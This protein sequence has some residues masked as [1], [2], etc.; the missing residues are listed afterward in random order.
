MTVQICCGNIRSDDP[1]HGPSRDHS[2]APPTSKNCYKD[3]EFTECGKCC[4]DYEEGGGGPGGG[5]S[6]CTPTDW[7]G[8]CNQSGS[9]DD[10]Y[11]LNNRKQPITE[12]HWENI[13]TRNFHDRLERSV[14]RNM[15]TIERRLRENIR[16]EDN[17]IRRRGGFSRYP[18]S[19]SE[20]INIDSV[21][22]KESAS[23]I[24]NE[25]ALDIFK[26]FIYFMGSVL[27]VGLGFL[28]FN[29]FRKRKQK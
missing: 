20:R 27:F 8:Y 13:N 19:S 24:A 22:N 15:D 9:E 6:S 14:S 4:D 7:G 11:Y 3:F 26:Y 28:V 23:E 16:H 1:V 2:R 10:Y 25:I 12:A 17:I 29:Y 21:L 18:R 5:P